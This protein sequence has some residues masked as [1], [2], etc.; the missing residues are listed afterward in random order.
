[1]PN[2]QTPRCLLSGGSA[3]EWPEPGGWTG[4]GGWPEPGGC[5]EGPEPDGGTV[6]C[7]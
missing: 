7:G 2:C 6:C 1:M 3:D 4:P 5:L